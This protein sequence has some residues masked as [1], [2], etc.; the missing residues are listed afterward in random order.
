[1][2]WT[3]KK[4]KL[5]RGVKNTQK[6]YTKTIFM[7]QINHSCVIT[8][9]EPDI[10]ECKAKRALGSITWSKASGSDQIPVELFKILKDDAV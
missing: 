3:E 5:L 8:Y 6:N 7:T 10:L 4:Q 9:L 1:M 2:V